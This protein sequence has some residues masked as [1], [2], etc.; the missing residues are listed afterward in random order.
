MAKLNKIKLYDYETINQLA[1]QEKKYVESF[2][3]EAEILRMMDHI[4]G[5]VYFLN[6]FESD[7]MAVRP[8][9]ILIDS[10]GKYILIDR[11]VM[12]TKTNYEVALHQRPG[13]A[14]C[15]YLSPQ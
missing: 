12:L 15:C 4:I 2:Y 13:T 6:H 10:E 14:A 5:A 3:L 9:N 8:D 1:S 11:K 7:H